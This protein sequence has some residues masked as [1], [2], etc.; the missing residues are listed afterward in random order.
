M[1]NNHPTAPLNSEL[2]IQYLDKVKRAVNSSMKGKTNNTGEVTLNAS[3]TSTDVIENLCNENSV[4]LLIP[5]T[6]NAAGST[7]VYVVAGDKTFTIHHNSTAATDKTFRY[8][9]VG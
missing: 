2:S 7:G 3:Q 4:V 6:S 9:I 1:N 5:V 8:I